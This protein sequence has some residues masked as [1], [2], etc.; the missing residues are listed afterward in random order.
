MII[1]LLKNQLADE[2]TLS[3]NRQECC[4]PDVIAKDSN[5]SRKVVLPEKLKSDVEALMNYAGMIPYPY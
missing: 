3:T 2:A 4:S 5:F 1:E